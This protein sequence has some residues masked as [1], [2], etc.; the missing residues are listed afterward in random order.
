MVEYWMQ[1]SSN[2]QVLIYE[3]Y[4]ACI[5]VRN[6]QVPFLVLYDLLLE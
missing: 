3:G 4:I 2:K 5:A 1:K 6:T